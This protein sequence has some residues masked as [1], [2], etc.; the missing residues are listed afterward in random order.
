MSLTQIQQMK[1]WK[2]TNK[3]NNYRLASNA[4]PYL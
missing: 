2:Y 3:S 4:Y 1:F